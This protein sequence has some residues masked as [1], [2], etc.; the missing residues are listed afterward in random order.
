VLLL[1]RRVAAGEARPGAG[2]RTTTR[3]QNRLFFSRHPGA[4][5]QR[6]TDGEIYRVAVK[7][8]EPLRAV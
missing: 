3:G 6:T 4:S 2:S 8:V 5:W 1:E 7:V